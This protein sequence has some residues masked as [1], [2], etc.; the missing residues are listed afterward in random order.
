MEERTLLGAIQRAT[1]N[2]ETDAGRLAEFVLQRYQLFEEF[3][4]ILCQDE[5]YYQDLKKVLIVM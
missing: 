2:L 4:T 1:S 5:A 3:K